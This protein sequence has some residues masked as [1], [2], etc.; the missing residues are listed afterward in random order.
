M[1]ITVNDFNLKHTLESGQFFRYYVKDGFYYI[2]SGNNFFKI[3]QNRKKLEFFGTKRRFV[4]EFLG[5]KHDFND[6][7]KQFNK[8]KHLNKAMK[9]YSGLRIMKQQPWETL[10]S[11][12]CSSASNIPKITKNV[13]LLTQTFGRKIHFEN[14]ETHVMPE[15]GEMNDLEKIKNCKV[16][17]RAK[18]LFETNKIP[19]DFFDNIENTDYATA[20]SKLTTLHGVGEKIADCVLLFG[21]NKLEAFP[22][23][24][25]IKK[26]M[27]E[28]YFENKETPLKKIKDFGTNKFGK[29]AGYANQY[30]YHWRRNL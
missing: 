9:Q 13:N 12:I 22:V 23:D 14:E 18:Y 28:L 3:R 27:Q 5:L 20:L 1:H 29:N 15:I 25:W 24:V 7:K 26:V 30:L 2:V 11:F 16:G 4:K 19:T 6:I 8:D 21:C 17:F 10:I